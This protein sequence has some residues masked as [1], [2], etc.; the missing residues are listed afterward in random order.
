MNNKKRSMNERG[1]V[2]ECD[3]R[4][5]GHNCSKRQELVD[6]NYFDY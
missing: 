6:Y 2:A 1:N 4:G 3:T 5:A